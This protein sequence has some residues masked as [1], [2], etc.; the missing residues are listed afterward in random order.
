MAR[1]R[2]GGPD[3]PW[4]AWAEQML[5]VRTCTPADAELSTAAFERAAAT[6]GARDPAALLRALERGDLVARA[7]LIDELMI[8]EGYF[9]R[10]PH[11]FE[12]V[13][14]GITDRAARPGPIL[15]WSA[16][17]ASGEE[18]WSMAIVAVEALG[19]AQARDRV[20][21][22]GTDIN[23]NATR[24]ATAGTYRRWSLRGLSAER[25]HTWL[26]PAGDG[27]RVKDA[28]RAITR[29]SVLDLVS[30]VA[31]DAPVGMDVILCRNVLLYLT[32]GAA[33]RAWSTVTAALGADGV[34]LVAPSDPVPAGGLLT[35][36]G[37]QAYRHPA[38]PLLVVPPLPSSAWDS[39]PFPIP[40]A[41]PLA[42]E[43]ED[44]AALTLRACSLARVGRIDAA[45][46]LA[47]RVLT[48]LDRDDRGPSPRVTTADLRFICK[49]VLDLPRG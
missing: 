33:E 1:S 38:L 12:I 47:R 11:Q 23:A 20:R 13:R 39:A 16:A 19:E 48:A 10:H 26:A 4:L 31:R 29:F 46:A 45:H 17:C 40:L 18:A 25:R 27:F 28:L 8:G 7:A 15:L 36:L 37:G 43:P 14:R 44:A 35:S 6:V 5:G 9:F 2:T 32:P 42:I 21:I 3:G 30:P 24:R 34:V 49:Q 22:L 41:D